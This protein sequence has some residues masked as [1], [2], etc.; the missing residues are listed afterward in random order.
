[1]T[2]AGELGLFT[3]AL[4]KQDGGQEIRFYAPPRLVPTP[5]A[6]RLCPTVSS[7]RGLRRCRGT[8]A[9]QWPRRRSADGG[10]WSH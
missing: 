2:N 4:V 10:R 9:R 6:T 5:M 1:M 7:A 3:N 8:N